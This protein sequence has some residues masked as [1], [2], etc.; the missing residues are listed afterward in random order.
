MRQRHHPLLRPAIG[1]RPVPATSV[2]W[3][4]ASATLADSTAI[5]SN[6]GAPTAERASRHIGA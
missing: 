4:T 3:D 5:I 1:G 6:S 2:A